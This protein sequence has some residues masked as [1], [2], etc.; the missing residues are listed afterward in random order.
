[1][2][3][4]GEDIHAVVIGLVR[5]GRERALCGELRSLIRFLLLLTHF[6][7]KLLSTSE[8]IFIPIRLLK[9]NLLLIGH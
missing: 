5:L 3:S 8:R 2:V 6:A 9:R 1:L 4:V 7:E